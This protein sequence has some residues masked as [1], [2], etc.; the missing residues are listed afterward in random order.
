MVRGWH[1]QDRCGACCYLQP[2][3]R[4]DLADDL[5]PAELAQYRSLVGA[6]GWCRHYDREGR[7]CRI[8]A[9]RPE[10]CRVTPANFQRLYGVEPDAFDEFAVNCCFE[11]IADIFGPASPEF[12]RYRRAYT[13]EAEPGAD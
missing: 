4:P 10:F 1:C 8:Y 13:T 5:T 11:H 6:D 9:E 12:D 7:R 3:E 2:A